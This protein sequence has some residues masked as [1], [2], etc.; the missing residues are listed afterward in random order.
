MA[1]ATLFPEVFPVEGGASEP[2]PTP[3]DDFLPVAFLNRFETVETDAVGLTCKILTGG[4]V[5]GEET[6]VEVLA[7]LT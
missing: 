1:G 6:G 3:L 4:V 2:V 5:G 7:A